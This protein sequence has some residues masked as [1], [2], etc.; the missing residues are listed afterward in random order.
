MPKVVIIGGG[1]VGASVAHRL[2]ALGASV[3]LIDR[4]DPGQATAAGA[5]IL[6]PLDHFVRVEAV[7]PLLRA[8]RAAYPELIA[9]LQGDGVLDVGYDVVGALQV[10][11][12]EEELAALPELALECERRRAEGFAHVGAVTRLEPTQARSLFPLLGP[13]VLGAVHCAGGARIDGRRL[14]AALHARVIA[15]G[16]ELRLGS[17]VITER[18]GRASGVSL[19][20]EEVSA[21]AVVVAAGAWSSQALAPLGVELPVRPQRGQLVHL[22]LEGQATGK[23]PVVLG[24]AHQYLLGFPESRVVVG[25][26][27]ED[28]VGYD[29]RITAG[30]VRSVLDEALRLAPGLRVATLTET[31]VGFRPISND[32]RPLLGRLPEHPN[33]FVA[34]GHGG[35]GLELGPYSGALVAELLMER[36]PSI[37]LAAFAPGRFA[38]ARASRQIEPS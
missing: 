23:W 24:F 15:A 4:R 32:G 8:A 2:L 37:D 34:T 9:E 35:Y 21:D 14:L 10:A 27:R 18:G 12:S 16:A 26:T 13:A 31:R 11:S 28:G 36:M 1:V 20:G 22:A 3:V 5:G 33:V 30:G 7:L 38:A 6:P 19:D 29:H 25:A 17:A